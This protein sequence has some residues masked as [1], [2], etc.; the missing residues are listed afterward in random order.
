MSVVTSVITLIMYHP[1]PP[2]ECII[3]LPFVGK[4]EPTNEEED[5][6]NNP[7]RSKHHLP[8]HTS[9]LPSQSMHLHTPSV[10]KD[11]PTICWMRR[12]REISLE[13]ARKQSTAAVSMDQSA[14]GP[15]DRDLHRAIAK[16][17]I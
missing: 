16:E 7:S 11:E 8:H 1:S 10:G 17:F 3:A 6:C 15:R 14:T 2:E 4:G 5:T 9:H 12:R 13:N